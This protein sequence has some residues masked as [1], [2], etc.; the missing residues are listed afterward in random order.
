MVKIQSWRDIPTPLGRFRLATD[1]DGGLHGGWHHV[2]QLPS[3]GREDPAL[4]PDLATWVEAAMRGRVEPP[5]PFRIP[6]GPDFFTACWKACRSIPP[7]TVWSYLE[8]ARSAGRPTAH[9]AAGAAMRHNPCP[10]FVPCHR[11]VRSDGQLGGF[12]GR[13]NPQD[14]ALGLKTN[15]LKLENSLDDLG[16]VRGILCR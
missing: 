4:E 1:A 15:L 16:R 8:L 7:G 5:P 11:V 12:A 9:R 2:G 6:T 10:L 14:A 13:T 3:G